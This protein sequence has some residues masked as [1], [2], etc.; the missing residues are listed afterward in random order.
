[1]A[2]LASINFS[3]DSLSLK[4]LDSIL[5]IVTALTFSIIGL[6]NLI[7]SLLNSN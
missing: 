5:R 3:T 2:S 7:D 6:I 4:S 1:M